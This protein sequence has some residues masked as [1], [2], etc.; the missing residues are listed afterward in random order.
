V[1]HLLGPMP[2]P[3]VKEKMLWADT[4]LHAAASEGFCNAV[5]EA[6]AMRLPVV[7]SDADGLA[8]NVADGQTG[9]VVPRRDPDA[10]AAKLKLLAGD[11][12][13]RQRLGEAGRQRVSTHFQ[14]ADQIAAFEKFYEQVLH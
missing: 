10:M 13:L 5:L 12:A 4:F 1:V 7:C 3:A 9:F 8:E 2:P 11:Y 6:Q 14:L